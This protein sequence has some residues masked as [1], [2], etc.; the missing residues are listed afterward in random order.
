MKT[1]TTNQITTLKIKGLKKAIGE[2]KRYNAG[3]YYSP[4]YGRLMFDIESGELWTDYFYSIGHNSW[5]Q[6]HSES[7]IN[8]GRVMKRLGIEINMQNVKNFIAENIADNF[9]NVRMIF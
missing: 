8:L 4:E 9:E 7:I 5:N 2:Y 3:G 1:T 6:Y